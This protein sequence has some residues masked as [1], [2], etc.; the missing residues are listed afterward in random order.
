MKDQVFRGRSTVCFPEM[1]RGRVG[2]CVATQIAR[3]VDRFSRMPGWMSPEQARAQTAG[4]LA[5][6][7]EMEACGELV[8]ILSRGGLGR[9]LALWLAAPAGMPETA[10]AGGLPIGYMLSLEGAD[11]IVSFRHLEQSYADG[12]RALGPVHYGPGV[13]GMGTDAARPR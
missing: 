4:Q 2:L 9:H 11:S 6:Y 13:Y 12:L 1:R 8:Q 10:A 3:S 5:W 7:R